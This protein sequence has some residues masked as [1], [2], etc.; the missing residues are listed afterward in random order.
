MP[1]LLLLFFFFISLNLFAQNTT[2]VDSLIKDLA[3][4]QSDT[5]K[6]KT[7]SE[8]GFIYAINNPSLSLNYANKQ[9]ALAD[10]VNIPKFSA[11]ALNDMAIASYYLG[12]FIDALEYNR[13]AL[14]IRESLGNKT[15]IVSSLNK[16]AIIYQS[17]GNYDTAIVYQFKILRLA[18]A[19]ENE[20]FIGNTYN[21]I[22]AM[23]VNLHNYDKAEYYAKL[24]VNIG[25]KINDK[26]ITAGALGSIGKN[27]DNQNKLD[28]AKFYY[29]KSNSLFIELNDLE[30][31]A[32][33]YYYLG[34]IFKK[35]KENEASLNSYQKAYEIVKKIGN[36]NDMALYEANIGELLV[37]MKKYPQGY[38]SLI[39]AIAVGSKIH[40]WEIL[41]TAYNS[42]SLYHFIAGNNDSGFI[43]QNLFQASVDSSL[44]AKNSKQITDLQSSY[45]I[46]K[47]QNAINLLNKENTIQKLT[48]NKNKIYLGVVLCL[49]F[50]SIFIAY[51]IFNRNQIRQSNKL[52]AEII[53]QQDL[54]TKGII[55]AEERERKR[56]AGDLHDGVGQLFSTVKMNME[57]LLEKFLVKE[58]TA[59]MLAEKT[60]ALVDE[61]CSEV[62]SIAHQ[63][64]PN[65][66]MKAGLVSAVRD[67]INKIPTNKL[68]I[69]IQANGINEHLNPSIETVLYRVIQESVN[70][71][72]KHADATQLDITLLSDPTEITL[73]IE[74]NGRGF[75]STD[76]QKFEGI[77]LKN[78]ASRIALIKGSFDVSSNTGNGTLIAIHIPLV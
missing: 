36:E 74:D 43:Y 41:K 9:K 73:S 44:S 59:D 58:P 10:K 67:F 28:S 56:I 77:G 32:I 15:L 37:E 53:V 65:A 25:L 14:K 26:Y 57:I 17:I 19:L 61:S 7:L 29:K 1:K 12:K 35:S 70:N 69:A 24:A 78:M 76:P 63:I 27:F 34:I 4:Q 75:D 38:Q 45:D 50:V 21:N 2:A 62:R 52:Q 11:N 40:N 3:L 64:M 33:I 23:Y 66:L 22:A 68:K 39:N 18:E 54:A 72:I 16:I 48:I 20:K 55:D 60:M 31:Q 8:L 46:E 42:L 49:L 5:G 51:L 30:K 6:I 71:V 47:K 13:A